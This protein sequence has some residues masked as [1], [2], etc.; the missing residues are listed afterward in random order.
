MDSDT[1]QADT[2][3]NMEGPATA[4]ITRGHGHSVVMMW[5]P[6]ILELLEGKVQNERHTCT[7][8]VSTHMKG[9]GLQSARPMEQKAHRERRK[10][11]RTHLGYSV[12]TGLP[13]E[14]RAPLAVMERPPGTS[15]GLRGSK[16]NCTR[17]QLYPEGGIEG[18]NNVKPMQAED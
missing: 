2:G 17:A 13:I 12:T 15:K 1:G 10:K 4:M 16:I 9:T 18:T 6:T 8:M 5:K 7:Q 3:F 14:N 11:Y